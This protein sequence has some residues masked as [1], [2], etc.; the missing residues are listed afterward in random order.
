MSCI[1][2]KKVDGK[3]IEERVPGQ[4]VAEFLKGE[5]KSSPSEFVEKKKKTIKKKATKED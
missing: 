3:V 1:L 5:Y 2:Y 4:K